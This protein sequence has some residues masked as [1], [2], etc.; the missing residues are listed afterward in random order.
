MAEESSRPAFQSLESMVQAFGSV[1]MMLESTFFAIHSSFRA[2]LGVA[3]NFGRMRGMLAQVFSALTIFKAVRWAYH[4][5]LVLF[6]NILPSSHLPLKSFLKC[7]TP[8]AWKY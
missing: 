7:R 5:L 8:Q 4:Q 3:E 2:V 6:G 1:S